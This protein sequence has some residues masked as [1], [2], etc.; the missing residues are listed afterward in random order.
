MYSKKNIVSKKVFSEEAPS[1][2]SSRKP[3]Y[4]I[5]FFLPFSN[6]FGK[7]SKISQIQDE[8]NNN[9]KQAQMNYGLTEN[10][11]RKILK[12]QKNRIESSY[13]ETERNRNSNKSLAL[14]SAQAKVNP[15]LGNS[16]D[17]ST[18]EIKYSEINRIHEQLKNKAAPPDQSKRTSL[19]TL[20]V[21][22][23]EKEKEVASTP[24]TCDKCDGKHPTDNCPYFKKQRDAH[25]DAQRKSAKQIGGSSL[26]PGSYLLS[27][28]V[29]RQPGM[30]F[31]LLS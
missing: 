27:A 16:S 5:N 29:V 20:P 2:S 30:F 1:S 8:R 10:P 25:P 6:F 7:S 31:L 13:S 11:Q 26:L 18:E 24:A 4:G 3:S 28:R 15:V 21:I 14:G 17:P 9:R 23:K 19:H 22:V 12:S